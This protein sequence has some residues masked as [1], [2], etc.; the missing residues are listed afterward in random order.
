MLGQDAQVELKKQGYKLII[1]EALDVVEIYNGLSAHDYRMLVKDGW[2][3]VEEDTGLLKWNQQSEEYQGKHSEVRN[4]CLNGSL[5][6][7][8]EKLIFWEFPI[9]FLDCFQSV[10]ILTYC[11]YGSHMAVYLAAGGVAFDMKAIHCG[12]L[13][14]WHTVDEGSIKEKLRELVTVYEGGSNSVGNHQPPH[15]SSKKS[16]NPLSVTWYRNQAGGNKEGLIAL[17]GGIYNFFFNYTQTPSDLNLWT[18]FKDYRNGLCGKGYTKG[19]VPNNLRATNDYK[20]KKA[21]AYTCNAFM[22]PVVK[23]YL[24][25]RGVPVYE[26]LYSLSEMLQ[27]IWRTAVRDYQAVYLYIPSQRMREL[28]YA[29]LKADT[30]GELFEN[31]G[32]EMPTAHSNTI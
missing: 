25:G 11:F 26:D 16:T 21:A 31:L 24:Q 5:V 18:T 19:F 1:D 14:D 2:L 28:F 10:T 12:E 27:W 23:Q 9:S 30:T 13:V 22:H 32:F 17:K 8:S 6:Y 4:L 7:Q 15:K 29:W 20:H 3:T